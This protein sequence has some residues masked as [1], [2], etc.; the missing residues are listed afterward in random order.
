MHGDQKF[1]VTHKSVD[2]TVAD[3]W[4]QE[5]SADVLGNPAREMAARLGYTDVPSARIRAN[6]A[7]P[8]SSVDDMSEADLD[9]L[10][11]GMLLDAK[12]NRS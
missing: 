12:E 2:A 7:T 4:K 5:M 1:L 9:S 8:V 3:R 10:L 11:S 6:M